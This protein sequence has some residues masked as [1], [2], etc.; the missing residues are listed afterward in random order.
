MGLALRLGALAS[1]STGRDIGMPLSLTI[2]FSVGIPALTLICYTI[3][4]T[5]SSG[6]L[7]LECLSSGILFILRGNTVPS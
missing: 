5:I 3:V 6:I 4:K 2:L 1:G 7:L